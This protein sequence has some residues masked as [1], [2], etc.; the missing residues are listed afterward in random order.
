VIENIQQGAA[1][2]AGRSK[3]EVASLSYATARA[4]I[5]V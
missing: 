4:R 3:S 1:D 2:I 5:P